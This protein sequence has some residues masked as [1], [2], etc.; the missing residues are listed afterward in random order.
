MSRSLLLAAPLV[1]VMSESHGAEPAV[2][3]LPDTIV[4]ATLAPSDPRNIGSALTVITEEEIE[5][6]QATSVPELLRDVQGLAVS[7]SG[8]FGGFTQIR[9]RGTEA[10]QVLFLVDGVEANDPNT[11]EPLWGD[12]LPGDIERIE[13]LRGS[14]SSLHGSDAIGGVIHII[15]KRGRG[16]PKFTAMAETGSFDTYT[17]RTG[18]SGGGNNYHY[19]ANVM[20]FTTRGVSQSKESTVNPAPNDRDGYRNI[21]VS[22]KLGASPVDDLD[23]EFS[24][25]YLRSS[26]QIDNFTASN[27]GPDQIDADRRTN[28]KQFFGGAKGSYRLFDDAWEHVA[29]VQWSEIAATTLQDGA[30]TSFD[31]SNGR[32]IKFAYH[33]NLKYDLEALANSHH[34][35]TVGLETE[36]EKFASRSA[37]R[38]RDNDG[39][40]AE[41]QLEL[42]DRL[43][44]TG[45][46]RY[47]RN[48][49]FKNADTWRG[50]AAYR[51]DEWSTKLRLSYATGVKNPTFSELFGSSNGFVGN[52][53]LQPET[54][55]SLDFGI[56][57][58][59]WDDRVQLDPYAVI[60]RELRLPR[61]LLALAIGGALGMAGAA[62]QGLLR[63]PL[64]EPGLIGVSGSAALGAVI[65]FYSGLSVTFAL[66]L[67]VGGIIGA[68]LSVVVLY[69]LA[70]RDP[71][72]LTLILAGVA[73]NALAGAL[74]T[75]AL[76]LSPN[77][78]AAFEVFFW[79]L[80]SLADRSLDHVALA[81]PFILAGMGLLAT[82][83]R[84]LDALTLGEDV[85]VSLGIGLR[86]LQA[87]II[88]G[89][90]L[91]VGASVA[92]AGVIGFVGLVVPH[93]LRP[94]VSHR[95]GRLLFASAL[96][97]ACL[98]LAADTAVRFAKDGP[99]L[100]LGVLTA[101]IGAPFFLL[102][103]LR[104]RGETP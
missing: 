32:K 58:R 82:T 102:L 77:P 62:L 8:P 2:P 39:F 23:L 56:E 19:A 34:T 55:R 80:G 97:G 37:K 44:L 86:G 18:V 9:I 41:Y 3:V 10:N 73:I 11:S 28:R 16:K 30:P 95:P 65:T 42:W 76:N 31:K 27:E 59:L 89:T 79:L 25:R 45:S 85:A 26:S 22:T 67:P 46:G 60:L 92:V 17:A 48:D 51:L 90:A 61:A 70:G 54:N 20:G 99:E 29:R 24:A 93:L 53:N 101:L 15:T 49:V 4:T 96:G 7:R 64:A 74:T 75:L 94:F 91:A 5:K 13:V 88:I 69:A 12:I 47:D 71:S 63:N 57:Q 36:H 21:T 52:P 78:Y 50:T 100:Q 104:T 66:A 43:T 38:T 14:Q 33:N 103:V 35:L 87:R 84:G 1:F 72:I 40:F 98:T 83:G 6:R 81:G 68:G